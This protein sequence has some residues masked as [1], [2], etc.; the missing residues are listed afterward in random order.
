M[1]TAV[2]PLNLTDGHLDRSLPDKISDPVLGDVK[3]SCALDGMDEYQALVK[4]DGHA[5]AFDLYTDANGSLAPCIRRA[6]KIVENFDAIKRKINKYVEREIFDTY[7]EIWNPDVPLADLAE[8]LNALKLEMITAHPTPHATFWY[9]AGDL[10]HGHALQIRMGER[11][12]IVDHD[13]PG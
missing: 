4:L 7:D 1:I 10:F 13:M 12:K 8:M 6:R 9:S 5:I 2:I 3:F 11:N